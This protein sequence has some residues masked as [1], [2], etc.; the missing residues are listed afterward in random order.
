MTKGI[1][2][3]TPLNA[4]TAK[5]IAKQGYLFVARYL[6]PEIY[7][8]KRLTPSEAKAITAAGMQII[9]VYETTANRA[10]GGASA[11]HEDG[12]VALN[13]A[14]L[15]GQPTGSAIYFAV[16]YDAQPQGYD[17]IE[18]YLE[19][20]TQQIPGYSCGVYGSYAVVEEMA[21]RKACQSFWQ[22]Y[23]WSRGK[24]SAHANLYQYRNNVTVGGVTVDLNDSRGREGWWNTSGEI[25][26][27]ISQD[28]AEKIIRLLS[29]AWYAATTKADKDEFH[30]LANEVRKA[31]GIPVE[32]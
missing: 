16:D 26:L 3:S 6:V 17:T 27:T 14:R 10:T 1:D 15:V 2:C 32:S 5:D 11:G 23:A 9:S 30:R 4:A 31:S 29:A 21:K 25:E 20:A 12:A 7:A 28:D 8:W 24:E 22:T 13:E 19:A 18:K